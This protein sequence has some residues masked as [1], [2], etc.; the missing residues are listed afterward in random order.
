MSRQTTRTTVAKAKAL[1][2]TMSPPEIA[3]WQHLRAATLKFRRQHP[4]GPYVLD[5]YC[6]STKTGIEVDGDNHLHGDRPL[7]DERR[8]AFLESRGLTL[9]RFAATDILHDSAA[10]ADRIVRHCQAPPPPAAVPLPTAPPQG[11]KK[12]SPSRSDGEVAARS[13]DGGATQELA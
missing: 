3:L 8:T 7:R 9:L 1:R 6:P 4:V 13:A 5:F 11:G 12:S 2:R 10:V